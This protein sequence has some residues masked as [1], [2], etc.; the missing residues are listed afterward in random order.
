[1]SVVIYHIFPGNVHR[2]VFSVGIA[3]K[4]DIMPNC[5]HSEIISQEEMDLAEVDP[6]RE[7]R[8][9][10]NSQNKGPSL[11]ETQVKGPFSQQC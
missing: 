10:K 3:N 7:I 4:M 1:M 9:T 2:E 5:A 11:W 8:K 6:S